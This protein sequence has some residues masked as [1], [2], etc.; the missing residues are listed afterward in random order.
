M[1]GE[2]RRVAEAADGGRNHALNRS[3]FVLGQLVG[4]GHLDHE[5]VAEALRRAGLAIGLGTREV[6]ATI[7]S[8]LVAGET[9]PRHPS[10]GSG[11][12]CVGPDDART[13]GPEDSLDLRGCD[14]PEVGDLSA[15]TRPGCGG[16]EFRGPE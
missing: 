13:V 1:C 10:N 6:R 2:L 11:R 3:A 8:G 16:V 4:G 9:V 15:R 7:S 12:P 14:L 5:E